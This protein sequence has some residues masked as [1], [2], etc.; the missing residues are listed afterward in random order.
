MDPILSAALPART[1]LAALLWGAHPVVQ[2]V[3]AILAVAVFVVLTVLIQKL[4]EFTLARRRLTAALRL[5][6]QTTT[7]AD[8]AARL[9]PAHGPAPA[10]TRLTLTE[11]HLAE[12]EA[13]LRRRAQDRTRAGLARIEAEAVRRLRTGT[14]LLASIGAI[15]PFVGLFGTV[16]GILNSFLAIAEAKTTSLV[17]VAPGIA[18]ALLATAIG[19]IAAIPAV[20]VYNLLIRRLATYRQR[21]G[22][23]AAGIERLQSLALDRLEG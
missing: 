20:L 3:M 10:M 22:D 7:L 21:L 19:L 14:G 13:P 12:T 16:F 9:T 4:A 23:F 2:A 17:V 18:E 8:L 1:D 15:A 5:L 11:L 6:E